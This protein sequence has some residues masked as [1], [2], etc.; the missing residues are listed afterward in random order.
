MRRLDRRITTVTELHG[1]GDLLTA[2]ILT[3]TAG[4]GR[5]RSEAAFASC[6]DTDSHEQETGS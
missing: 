6:C 2:K 3:R 5:F 1:I 4:V